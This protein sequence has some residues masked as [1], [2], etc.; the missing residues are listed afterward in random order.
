LILRIPTISGKRIE[1]LRKLF[2]KVFSEAVWRQPSVILLDDLDHIT[3]APSGPE[4]ECRGEALY[5]TRVSE[6]LMLYLMC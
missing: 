4:Q 3:A 6:G 2:Q 1:G 5:Y